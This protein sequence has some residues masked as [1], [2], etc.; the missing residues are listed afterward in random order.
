MEKDYS[1]IGYCPVK[2]KELTFP[3]T[4]VFNYDCWEKGTGKCPY[5]SSCNVECPVVD[6]APDELKNL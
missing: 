1:W 2:G 4:Y 3:I 6:S 5:S